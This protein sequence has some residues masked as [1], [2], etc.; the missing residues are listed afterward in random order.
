MSSH[1]GDDKLRR[2]AHRVTYDYG[3]DQRRTVLVI[4]SSYA[5][6]EEKFV[7]QWRCDTPGAKPGIISIERFHMEP[8]VE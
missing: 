5:E 1:A 7:R 2:Y 6:A 3:N 8:V 4:A